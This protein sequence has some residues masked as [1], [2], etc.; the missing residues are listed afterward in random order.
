[1]NI[2][3]IA[4]RLKC[5][6]EESGLTQKELSE[7]LY[8]SRTTIAGY[9]TGKTIPSLE[10]LIKYADFFNATTDWI[11]CRTDSK[12][13]KITEDNEIQITHHKD[14]GIS[15]AAI[16]LIKKALDKII[17]EDSIK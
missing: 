3:R 2:E 12:E 9:E 1:M 4:N 13:F 6:R 10:V 16:D 7:H 11:L 15:K 8:I 17:E 5:L 14:T